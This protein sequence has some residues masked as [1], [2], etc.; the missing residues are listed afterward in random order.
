MNRSR[1]ILMASFVLVCGN[2]MAPGAASA[3]ACVP[4]PMN[5][6]GWWPGDGDAADLADGNPGSLE[7]GATF[8]PGVV[9][10]AFSLDGAGAYVQ[11]PE[12]G[13]QLDGYTELT[14]DAWI[15]PDALGRQQAI[16]TKYDTQSIG[17]IYF[18]SLEDDKLRMLACESC[19][20]TTESFVYA[21]SDDPIAAAGVP[22]HVA[23][24]WRGGAQIELYANG[25]AIPA[26]TVAA[27]TVPT[28]IGDSDAP[29]DIGRF[30]AGLSGGAP[31]LFA[32]FDGLIDEVEIF[33][34]GLSAAEINAIYAAGS[35]GKCKVPTIEIAIDIKPGS[36]PNSINLSASGVIPVALLSSASF[37]APAD[38]NIESLSLAGASVRVA[39]KSGKPLCHSSDVNQD[40]RLDLV[41]QL[42][43]DLTAQVGDS[44]AVLEGTTL[45]GSIVRGQDS[46]RIVHD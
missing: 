43:N 22:V 18:L 20:A 7:A 39:G 11:I 37:A 19:G 34:R 2:L 38:T 26:T 14:L 40:S 41:C 1:S 31:E 3:S 8:A 15:V 28:I 24:V 33:D 32:Y 13:S 17:G 12:T 36:Y 30:H 16:V 21:T 35:A 25:V 5:M 23:G 44:V 27:A 9:G 10:P 6:T 45:G 42:E 46:I 29:V 4:P